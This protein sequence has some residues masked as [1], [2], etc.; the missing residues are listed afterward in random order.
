MPITSK[1]AIAAG[2]AMYDADDDNYFDPMDMRGIG[3][4][5]ICEELE[6]AELRD[7]ENA[8]RQYEDMAYRTNGDATE[9]AHFFNGYLK[10]AEDKRKK[11]CRCD[12]TQRLGRALDEE[13]AVMLLRSSSYFERSPALL[14]ATE[15]RRDALEASVADLLGT[16]WRGIESLLHDSLSTLAERV[17]HAAREELS[18]RGARL[19]AGIEATRRTAELRERQEC[20]V[21][22]M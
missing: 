2:K 9:A 7:M 6:G 15:A 3:W 18:E 21:T 20:V 14:A 22:E 11:Q 4:D 16:A 12:L 19:E 17:E 13:D 5:D 10:L 1:Q 8:I